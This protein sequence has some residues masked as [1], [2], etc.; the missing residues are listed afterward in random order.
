M[1]NITRLSP[2]FSTVQAFT[3]LA[4]TANTGAQSTLQTL[5]LTTSVDGA[6]LYCFIGRRNGTALTRGGE[7]VITPTQ[8][9]A[10]NIPIQAFNVVGQIAT[11]IST[12]LSAGS[13]IGDST[14]S[15]TSSTSF[16]VGD[17]VCIASDDSNANRVEFARVRGVGTNQ[18]TFNRALRFAHN[19]AD[20]IVTLAD[21]R[22]IALPPG[23]IYEIRCVN[24]VAGQDLIFGVYAQTDTGLTF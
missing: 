3:V 18:L 19:S 11:A 14:I 4:N 2:T 7:I 21:V 16:A 22:R 5:D 1:P 10:V 24:P 23:D 12:T 13:S 15:I 9:N 17:T 6:V 8:N 20:R